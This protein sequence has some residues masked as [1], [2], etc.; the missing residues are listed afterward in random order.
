MNREFEKMLV[1]QCAPTLAG[2]K[3]AN[4]FR[5]PAG[6]GEAIRMEISHWNKELSRFGISVRIMRECPLTSAVLIY[7]FRRAWV[8]KI[9]SDREVRGFLRQKGYIVSRK[10]E[11]VLRQLSRR[12]NLEKDFPHEIGIFLGYP[13]SD[14]IG[15]IENRG[16]NYTCCGFWKTYGDPGEARDRFDGYRASINAYTKMF[17]SG[18]P[19]I[20]LLTA[21]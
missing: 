16:Q 18:T 3:P 12:L 15:F 11:P 8:E 17:D 4:L 6:G 14:V 21:V 19:V 13:L 7:V 20:K 1:E 2:I 9:L 5:F 10:C